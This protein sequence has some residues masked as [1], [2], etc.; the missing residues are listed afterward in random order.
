MLDT[1]VKFRGKWGILCRFL[2]AYI[3]FLF[4]VCLFSIITI[5][6]NQSFIKNELIHHR[7]TY[8]KSTIEVIS[9][10][11]REAENIVYQMG[12]SPGINTFL[13]RRTLTGTDFYDYQRTWLDIPNYPI[14]N[15]FIIDL[16][17]H[18]KN[19]N[20]LLSSSKASYRPELFY[21]TM[22]RYPN[23]TFDEWIS[24]FL[25]PV[26]VNRY[27][28]VQ[29]V[30]IDF[31]K[32]K[33]IT[34]IQSLPFQFPQNPKG[35]IVLVLDA[36]ILTE[37]LESIAGKSGKFFVADKDGKKLAGSPDPH[38]DFNMDF[39]RR[40]DESDT[41]I[42]HVINGTPW[43]I[44]TEESEQN[45]WRC[46]VALPR[47]AVYSGISKVRGLTILIAAF[48]LILTVSAALIIAYYNTLPI[49]RMLQKVS[50]YSS[51]PFEGEPM[52]AIESTISS[53][54]SENTQFS[55]SLKELDPII[56]N[57]TILRLARGRYES[58]EKI[59]NAL[60]AR[61]I[62]FSPGSYLTV[63]AILESGYGDISEKPSLTK[64]DMF[65]VL[66]QNTIEKIL[67]DR[68]LT[69][70]LEDDI[71]AVLIS[72]KTHREYRRELEKFLGDIQ[73][74]LAANHGLKVFFTAGSLRE[75][76][77]D[78]Y[79]STAEALSTLDNYRSGNRAAV[80]WYDDSKEEAEAQIG[81]FY[82]L[83]IEHR[84]DNFIRS[85]QREQLQTLFELIAAEN[86]EKRNLSLGDMSAFLREVLSTVSKTY[87]SLGAKTKNSCRGIRSRINTLQGDIRGLRIVGD[88][89]RIFDNVIDTANRLTDVIDGVK[90][91]HNEKLINAVTEYIQAHYREPS[92]SLTRVADHLDLTEA[93]LSTFF[94]EHTGS[95]YS[96]Y[97]ERLRIG[98]AKEMLRSSI[99]IN[100]IALSVGYANKNTFYKAFKRSEGISPGAYRNQP[101]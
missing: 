4:L 55:R 48:G 66:V 84:L 31:K 37:P 20:V 59:T 52:H 45:G 63:A 93:Y 17:I 25:Q 27:E 73:S 22:I 11:I 89:R 54:I 101:R 96:T 10:R 78:L 21:S 61:G 79:I 46:T 53:L 14:V 2:T 8:L 92:L 75:S 69:C 3:A 87:S 5:S 74:A 60:S 70:S 49:R 41:D 28:E 62:Q 83:D 33:A 1:V 86:F 40:T 100:E 68:A 85:G 64:L 12:A 15:E 95:N 72:V 44:L 77:M 43:F 91:S 88:F 58:D 23:Y 51:L 76:L 56:R 13:N 24:G 39:L 90:L 97:I 50:G 71:I 57:R 32:R 47:S 6:L 81:Y 29:D 26:S 98:S 7:R 18:F 82:P 19:S 99:S 9:G 30:I 36:G 16:F 34:L 42:E 35:T 67:G 80:V 38:D 94:K 65:G